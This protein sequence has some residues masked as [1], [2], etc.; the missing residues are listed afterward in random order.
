VCEFRVD[1][2]EEGAIGAAALEAMQGIA[3]VTG[4]PL[5]ITCRFDGRYST[6]LLEL[7]RAVHMALLGITYRNRMRITGHTATLDTTQPQGVDVLVE[8][9]G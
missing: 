6:P 2:V 1:S 7:E 3:P 4:K 5:Y 8:C 9:L